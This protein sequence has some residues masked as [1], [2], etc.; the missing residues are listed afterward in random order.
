M[1]LVNNINGTV[2][3]YVYSDNLYDTKGATFNGVVYPST[4]PAIF[5]V[6]Y[7]DVNI[8]GRVMGDL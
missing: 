4:D 7:P 1:V 5:E 2:D 8:R 6:K 3:G